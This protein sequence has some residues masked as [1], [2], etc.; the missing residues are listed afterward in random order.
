[1]SEPLLQP[2][3]LVEA[4]AG[5]CVV[6]KPAG[7]TV[8]RAESNPGL[9]HWLRDE[10]GSMAYP[11]HRLDLGTT[12]LVVFALSEAVNRELSLAFAER[13]V[14][15]AYLAVS[16]QAPRKK[17][18]WVRGDMAP[19]RRGQWKLLRSQNNPAVTSFTSLSLAPGIRGFVL[20]PKTGKTHQ[21]RVA[22]KSLG[23]PIIGDQRYGGTPHPLMHLHA[24]QLSFVLAEQP[25]QFQVAPEGGWFDLW[26]EQGLPDVKL[27]VTK[28]PAE[29]KGAAADD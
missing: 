25:Y 4:A 7:W 28:K 21:L 5:F 13:R 2:R 12:G 9:V 22:L 19:S 1:M 14:S 27:G 15:K 23:S 3:V 24:W 8:Q 26:C 10:L 11:V 16:D 6:V 29:N 18:G 17:Q 20:H